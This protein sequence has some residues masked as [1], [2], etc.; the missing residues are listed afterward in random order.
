[1]T[2]TVTDSPQAAIGRYFDGHATGSSSV[3]C[4]AFHES[5][6]VQFVKD[7]RYS[8]WS[9]D[10]YL[11]KLPGRPADDEPART[12][13]IVGIH[14]IGEHRLG[15]GGARLSG[16]A[17]R[18][19]PDPAPDRRTVAHREQG[20]PGVSQ[21][22]SAVVSAQLGFIGLGTMGRPMFARLA[23]A[24]DAPVAV[25]S[26]S[27][28]APD[29]RSSSRLV[30]CASPR[31]VGSRADV[32]FLMLPT[33]AATTD[34]LEGPAGLLSS[35]GPGKTVINS[36]TIGPDAAVACAGLVARTGAAYLDAPVLGS[37]PAAA[38]GMLLFLVGGDEEP[39]RRCRPAL[40]RLG[41]RIVHLGGVGRGSAAKLVFNALLGT[42]VAALADTFRLAAALGLPRSFV[43]EEVLGSP[44]SS[45]ALDGKRAALSGEQYE[46][47]F[48]LK[49][50][51]KDL[52]LATGTATSAGAVVP[53]VQAAQERFQDA[54][55]A[56][57]GDL[58][59]AALAR[60]G[61]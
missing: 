25:F 36:A 18:G 52:A 59:Y 46:P 53:V 17:F 41:R 11:G 7:G 23:D 55:T 39:L 44:V 58:D 26:R 22:G 16:D 20:L 2:D 1:M 40:E 32:V 13:R 42:S 47:Q 56:G 60:S 43:L 24:G 15:R 21:A 8:V 10:A 50:M 51:V 14:A 28:P 27:R 45:P 48:A 61:G 12:R 54:M 31:E 19:P 4:E 34:V 29:E 5:A 9:L 35:L 38:A 57:F 3:M 49:W 33:S 30:W 37:S 6:R